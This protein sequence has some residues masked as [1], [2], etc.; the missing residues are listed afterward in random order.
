MVLGLVPAIKDRLETQAEKLAN[1]WLTEHK[2]AIKGLSD[3]RQEAYRQIRET[4][5]HLL[6]VDLARPNTWMQP[7]TVR[8][9]NGT[10]RDLPRFERHFVCD[11]DGL[12]PSTLVRRGRRCFR[13]SC[14][15]RE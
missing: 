3:E 1:D 13:L 2:G 10:E 8:E 12:S 14:S 5:A 11:D 7:T 9:A 4:S 6:D 15:R